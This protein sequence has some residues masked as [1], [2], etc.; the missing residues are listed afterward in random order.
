MEKS[1]KIN[2][3]GIVFQISEDA[4]EL[5]RDYLQS[6]TGKL[7]NVEGGSEMMDDI[8][9]RIA[10]IFQSKPSWQTAVISK[11]EVEELIS[12]MGSPEEIAGDFESESYEA[13]SGRKQKKLYRN[14]SN[15]IIGGV[16]SG[17][18]DYTGIEAVWIRLA[19][20]LFTLVYFSGA[21][22][23][24]VLWIA[25]P[26][27]SP[28]R[29]TSERS[30]AG[31]SRRKASAGSSGE[32]GAAVGNAFNE[33]FSAFG[34]VFII[35]FRIVIAII[36]VG[37]ILAGFS[38]IFS[39]VLV[40][41]FQSTAFT[42]GFMSDSIF[43]LP[44]FFAF[45]V[46]PPMTV[47]L[48]I[49]T[50]IVIILPL[51]ALIYWGIRMV[52]QFRARDLAL[53][54]SM[55]IIWVVSCTSLAILLFTQGI[56]FSDSGRSINE[57][58]L[59]VADTLYVRL[60]NKVS[61]LDYDRDFHFPIE[62]YD[63]YFNEENKTIYGTPELYIYHSDE[64]PVVK[65]TKY[66]NSRSRADARRKAEDINYNFVTA[67]NAILLDEYFSLP[68]RQRWSGSFVKVRLY[69][70]DGYTIYFDED[71]EDIMHGDYFGCGLYSWEAGDK[72]WTMENG[73]LKKLNN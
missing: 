57:T 37:F 46:S 49:L 13:F 52:F 5:L 7:R 31:P 73:K 34:K 44:D 11:E 29:V 2:I 19:F 22:V 42:P 72:Y 54:L 8:E 14:T 18:A 48:T 40:T 51:L 65:V 20:V 23:Y 6:I 63:L 27:F 50:S 41:F 35:I 45:L 3:A 61:S 58:T 16:C 1:I 68:E 28:G 17:L 24:V 32:G 10:E 15:S 66:S 59:P 12:T 25:V 70:P 36:G 55:L 64:E 33:I 71:V 4:Y 53:N 26:G 9:S 38:A 43:N 30:A 39:F 60:D 62:D 21:V 47:W 67:G 69:I 56:S